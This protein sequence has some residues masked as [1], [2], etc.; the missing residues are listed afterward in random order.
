MAAGAQPIKYQPIEP[1]RERKAWKA[2][3]TH[4]KFREDSA[5]IRISW[6]QPLSNC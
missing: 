3:A 1:L 6:S 4:Y 5:L 2:L